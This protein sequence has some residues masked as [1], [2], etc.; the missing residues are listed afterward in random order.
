MLPEQS[1]FN[2]HDCVRPIMTDCEKLTGRLRDLCRG[3]DDDG[4]PVSTP[5]KREAWQRYFHGDPKQ[6]D[7]RGKLVTL[8]MQER[9]EFFAKLK[10]QT[11]EAGREAWKKLH[12]YPVDHQHDWDSKQA[13][14]WF[15]EWEKGIPKFGCSCRKHWDGIKRNVP[16][17]FSSASAF[18][19]WAIDA[20]N[21]VNSVLGKPHFVPE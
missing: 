8:R 16:P 1:Y 2:G 14:E 11:I 21:A 13:K 19:T 7:G 18:E 10:A 3:H 9:E 12:Q 20:H 4:E 15:A 5:A 6:G 17:V